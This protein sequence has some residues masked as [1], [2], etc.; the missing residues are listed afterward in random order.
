MKYVIMLMVFAGVAVAGFDGAQAPGGAGTQGAP[1]AAQDGGI[2]FG[3][4]SG[5]SS[6][7]TPGQSGMG[8]QGG[9]GGMGKGD[10]TGP[11]GSKGAMGGQRGGGKGK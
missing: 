11:W 9:M 4:G 10:G 6:V 7:S 1:M 3:A 8:G 2:G 5:Q